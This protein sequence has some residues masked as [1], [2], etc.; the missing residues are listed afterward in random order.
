MVDSILDTTLLMLVLSDKLNV[1][2]VSDELVITD[3]N[4]AITSSLLTFVVVELV[5]FDNVFV[6]ISIC[7]VIFAIATFSS[8]M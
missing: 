2:D 1:D 6:I 8:L 4:D 7:C 3:A 5:V